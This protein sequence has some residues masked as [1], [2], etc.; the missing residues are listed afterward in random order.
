MSYTFCKLV[1]SWEDAGWANSSDED[2]DTTLEMYLWQR[3][4]SYCAEIDRRV[5]VGINLSYH[6]T[7]RGQ[8]DGSAQFRGSWLGLRFPRIRQAING[9]TYTLSPLIIYSPSGTISTPSS[10]EN[11]LSTQSDSTTFDLRS[12][13]LSVP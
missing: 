7:E 10:A 8:S 3:V 2:V 4:C 13:A 9:N 5:L 6:G 1:L 11:S 12:K